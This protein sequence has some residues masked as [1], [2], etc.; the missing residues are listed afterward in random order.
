MAS[1]GSLP[2]EV[3]G[4][5][6]RLIDDGHYEG[7]LAALAATCRGF[8]R[9]TMPHLYHEV[10]KR[11]PALL[12]W[13][14]LFGRVATAKR[15]IDAGARVS[16]AMAWQ[17]WSQHDVDFENFESACDDLTPRKAY[18][19]FRRCVATSQMIITKKIK[20]PYHYAFWFPIHLAAMSGSVEMVELLV[21]TSPSIMARRC[22]RLCKCLGEDSPRLSPEEQEPSLCLPLHVATCHGHL[23]VVRL[24]FEH[25]CG[26]TTTFKLREFED[27]QWDVSTPPVH[28]ALH[29]ALHEALHD[30]A[31]FGQVDV[32][33][34]IL[35]GG[36]E[37]NVH[38]LD[39]RQYPPIWHAYLHGQWEAIDV[40]LA[41]GADIDDDVGYGYT[42]LI[43]ACIRKNPV[44]VAELIDRS[45][46]ANVVFYSAPPRM[47]HEHMREGILHFRRFEGIML[48]GSQGPIDPWFRYFYLREAFT[49]LRPATVACLLEHPSMHFDEGDITD[50][51]DLPL[52]YLVRHAGKICARIYFDQ[53]EN[54]GA[55]SRLENIKS[56]MGCVAAFAQAGVDPAMR[57][58]AGRSALDYL[59]EHIAYLG[60][61]RFRS[62]LA[63]VLRSA[64]GLN[65]G[66]PLLDP[67]ACYEALK[68]AD[69]EAE[70]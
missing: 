52:A 20:H 5:I 57:D 50:E 28:D 12:F 15:L 55:G 33:K 42:P 29:E 30:A 41:R 8:Y 7:T 48:K 17:P 19:W 23:D 10:V 45:A 62:R 59:G 26:L 11:H 37:T 22:Y 24:L 2:A 69:I 4:L 47:R 46:N 61:D 27:L 67:A 63:S 56:W 51:A 34:F 13:A 49:F 43:D 32:I 44:A 66:D 36:Y 70:E 40:L 35:D 3:F 39:G 65:T 14:A 54:V 25:G 18:R 31:R 60:R 16:T 21:S 6:A 1:L 9:L 38:V 64:G 58:R 53:S 68:G